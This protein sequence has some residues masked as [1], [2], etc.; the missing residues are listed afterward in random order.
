LE[1]TGCENV[2]FV[3]HE[4][5]EAIEPGIPKNFGEL[6]SSDQEILINDVARRNVQQTVLKLREQS[7]SLNRLIEEGQIAIV[8]ALYDVVSG[9]MEFLEEAATDR[10]LVAELINS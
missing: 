9:D 7:C 6:P 1:A 4:I 5:D 3:L 10:R 2:E 8:G